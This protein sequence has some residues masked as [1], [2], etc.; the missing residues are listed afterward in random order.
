MSEE[1]KI[2]KYR[3]PICGE[4]F[5]NRTLEEMEKHWACVSKTFP[6]TEILIQELH[7]LFTYGIDDEA[8]ISYEADERIATLLL[9]WLRG[10]K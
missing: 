3:C 10:K 7:D 6:R 4:V 9:K 8:V 5:T 2:I 1:K